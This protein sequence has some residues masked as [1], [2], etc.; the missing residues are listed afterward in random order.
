MAA[1]SAA[2]YSAGWSQEP[3]HP[4]HSEGMGAHMYGWVQIIDPQTGGWYW[5]DPFTHQYNEG[6]Q[7]QFP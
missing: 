4:Y 1:A 5:W 2:S 7:Q 3:L 6:Q